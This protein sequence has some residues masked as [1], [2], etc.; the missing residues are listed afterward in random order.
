MTGYRADTAPGT[1]D[2]FVATG[3][4]F[5]AQ[6]SYTLLLVRETSQP[7]APLTVVMLDVDFGRTRMLSAPV[8]ET[9]PA[10]P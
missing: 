7:D 10:R 1:A 5:E 9:A 2:V 3:L 8:E 4:E 6:R